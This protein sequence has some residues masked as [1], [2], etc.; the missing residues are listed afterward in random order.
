M[1]L[2]TPQRRAEMVVEWKAQRLMLIKYRNKICDDIR[3]LDEMIEKF[4]EVGDGKA[5]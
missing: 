2:T 3:V 1:S 5:E 4:G